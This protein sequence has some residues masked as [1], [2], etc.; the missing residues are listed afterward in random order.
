[1]KK[2]LLPIFATFLAGFQFALAQTSC[3]TFYPMMEGSSYEY[4]NYNK[5]GK[6]EGASSYTITSVSQ[7]G[8]VTKAVM[9][10][11]YTDKKGKEVFNSNY[12][13]SCDGDRV[14]ID[15]KSLFPSQMMKQYEEMG[16]EMDITGTDIELPNRLNVGEHLADANVAVSANIGGMGMNITVDMTNR[17]VEKQ[18]RITTPAGTFD[19]YLITETNTSK[20]MGAAQE[21]NSKLWLAEGV[22]MIKQELYRKNGDL[23]TRSELSQ[24]S[25]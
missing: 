25:K 1:M 18:E 6:V 12:S 4:T 8:S 3:S 24:F 2:P 21:M 19:C 17:K 11:K 16:L 22:G 9:D 5:K 13:I 14:R 23:M 7:E 15:Y 20:T 10:L